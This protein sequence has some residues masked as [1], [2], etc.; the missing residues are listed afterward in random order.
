MRQL[1]NDRPAGCG[2]IAVAQIMKYHQHPKNFS[3]NGHTFGWNTI[4]VYPD[5]NSDQAA[6]VKM[7]NSFLKASYLGG[8]YVTPG[9]MKDGL[10][11]IGYNV[12]VK[13]H[14][15]FN[16][17]QEVMFAKRPVIMLGND[18]NFSFLPGALQYVNDSHYW[19]CDGAQ[20]MTFKKLLLFTE[21]QPYGKGK[22]VPGWNSIE[23]PYD[24]GGVTYLSLHMNWGWGGKC[25]GWFYDYSNPNKA[26]SYDNNSLDNT[27]DKNFKHSRK[28]FYISIK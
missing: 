9:N 12:S 8:T 21:W 22:F 25:N 1:C 28:D 5:S 17:K 18:D 11:N 7:V 19:V 10:K 6:L 14:I 4:P 20:S 26:N 13:D 16:V 3:F 24:F 27:K 23:R 2:P 15:P